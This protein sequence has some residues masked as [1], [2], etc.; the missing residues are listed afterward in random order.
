MRK[1]RGADHV[2]FRYVTLVANLSGGCKR[3]IPLFHTVGIASALEIDF[4]QQAYCTR[5]IN[6]SAEPVP[7]TEPFLKVTYTLSDIAAV[8]QCPPEEHQGGRPWLRQGVVVAQRQQFFRRSPCRSHVTARHPSLAHQRKA[9]RQRVGMLQP[10]R[11]FPG[12]ALETH[13][14]PWPPERPVYRRAN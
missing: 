9:H 14:A 12:I 3:Q 5:E 4:C 11:Q 2:H 1:Q 6:A 7:D 13:A 8:C 10:L